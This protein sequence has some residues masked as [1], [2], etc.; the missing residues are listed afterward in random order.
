YNYYNICSLCKIGVKLLKTNP[1]LK[2]SDL[3]HTTSFSLELLCCKLAI[4]IGSFGIPDTLHKLQQYQHFMLISYH[5]IEHLFVI[6][7]STHVI[8]YMYYLFLLLL[9]T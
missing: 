7:F 6:I 3:D 4:K 1:G 5:D 9:Y 2:R 8:L